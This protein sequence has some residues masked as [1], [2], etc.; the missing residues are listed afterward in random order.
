MLYTSIALIV[1]AY[2]IG[3]IPFGLVIGRVFYRTDVRE[4]GSGNIGATNVYRTLGP[5]AG[6]S[7]LIADVLKGLIPVIAAKLLLSSY[8]ESVPLVGVAVGLVAIVGHSFSV[9]LKFSGGKGISTALGMVIALWPWVALILVSSWVIIT[10]TTRYVSLASIIAALMLPVVV[11]LLYSHS[12][13]IVFSILVGI[14]I[15]YRHRSN[16]LRLIKGKELKVGEKA[17]PS[18]GED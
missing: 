16:I 18:L 9:F 11:T 3:S 13:Y 10:A 15:V 5:V 12:A 6:I 7:V 14:V 8:P 17:K 4:Y 1:F 2:I